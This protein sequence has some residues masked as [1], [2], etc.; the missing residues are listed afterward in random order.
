MIKVFTG[1][2]L[3]RKITQ[4]N[5]YN[6]MIINA[7]SVFYTKKITPRFGAFVFCGGVRGIR[8]LDAG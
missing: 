4:K 3:L 5:K 8:T 2:H 1:L 6:S 7:F